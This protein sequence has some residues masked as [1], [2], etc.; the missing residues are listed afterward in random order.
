[1]T[2]RCPRGRRPGFARKKWKQTRN[3]HR[4]RG[5][6]GYTLSETEDGGRGKD[7]DDDCDVIHIVMR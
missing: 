4:N 5:F 7:E 3:Q 1:M 2:E 6:G